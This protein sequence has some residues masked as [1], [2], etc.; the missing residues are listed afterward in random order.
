MLV[1]LLTLCSFGRSGGRSVYDLLRR[2]VHD[3]MYTLFTILCC[4]LILV[5]PPGIP[6][7][8]G[9]YGRRPGV[10]RLEI[11]DVRRPRGLLWIVAYVKGFVADVHDHHIP[12]CGYVN[13]KSESLVV[14]CNHLVVRE[15]DSWFCAGH[16]SL[17]LP[18]SYSTVRDGG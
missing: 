14:G 6:A 15:V 13:F 16:F 12:W 8:V 9:W 10:I 1:C 17:C 3:N 2:Y 18:T 7:P 5:G 11:A 4:G